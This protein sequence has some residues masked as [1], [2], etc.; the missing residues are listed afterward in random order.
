MGLSESDAESTLRI[1]F[2]RF[3]TYDEI[4]VAAERLA[5]AVNRIGKDPLETTAE[6]PGAISQRLG[7]VR[8]CLATGRD[9]Q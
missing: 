8:S 3:N 1:G 2:G 6:Q 5:K 7:P 4:E 9:V